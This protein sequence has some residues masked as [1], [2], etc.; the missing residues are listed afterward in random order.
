[1]THEKITDLS[2]GA[3]QNF[4]FLVTF[5]STGPQPVLATKMESQVG[6]GH[7]NIPIYLCNVEKSP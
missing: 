6:L 5:I 3:Q 2:P 7:Q 1:M 4:L